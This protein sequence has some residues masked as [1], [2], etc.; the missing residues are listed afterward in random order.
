MPPALRSPSKF[1]RHPYQPA[2]ELNAIG[3]TL[4][5]IRNFLGWSQ[6]QLAIKCQLNGWDIDRVIIA[7]IESRIRAISDWELLKLSEITGVHPGVLLGVDA[8]YPVSHEGKPP[9]STKATGKT[10]QQKAPGPAVS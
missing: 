9:S 4:N 2:D 10:K 8:F 7:K 3:G 5:K 6:Q 1:A